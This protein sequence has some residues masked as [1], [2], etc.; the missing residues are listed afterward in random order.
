MPPAAPVPCRPP[1]FRPQLLPPPPSQV[2]AAMRVC[3]PALLDP[4]TRR[5]PAVPSPRPRRR[6]RGRR[7]WPCGVPPSPASLRRQHHGRASR[8]VVAN[9]TAR[10]PYQSRRSPRRPRRCRQQLSCA[11]SHSRAYRRPVRP[12]CTGSGAAR[13]SLPRPWGAAPRSAPS[14]SVQSTARPS[15]A[16]TA[17][18]VQRARRC[19]PR[20]VHSH[21]ENRRLRPRHEAR[22][23]RSSPPPP[24]P[25]CGAHQPRRCAGRKALLMPPSSHP[26]LPLAARR[27]RPERSPRSSECP[28]AA[29]I[30]TVRARCA[31]RSPPPRR[32][33]S[34][35]LRALPQRLR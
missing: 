6:H 23:S 8:G 21:Q 26:S 31:A 2:P 18:A 35:P 34:R 15:L 11:P 14:P 4:A 27:T 19:R 24:P 5:L 1:R 3:Q 16:A 7:R 13:A 29:A 12:P 9:E 17:G 33:P 22:G 32:S 20:Q 10:A 30:G 25:P 28:R